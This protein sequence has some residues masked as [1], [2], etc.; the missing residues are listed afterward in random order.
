[1]SEPSIRNDAAEWLADLISGN[2]FGNDYGDEEVTGWA[3]QLLASSVI[4]RIRAETIRDVAHS[5]HFGTTAQSTLLRR[6]EQIE[7]GNT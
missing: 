3:D 4:R 2:G 7:K 1:M 6:A 5:G